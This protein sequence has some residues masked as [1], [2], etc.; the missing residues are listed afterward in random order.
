M[1]C[2]PAVNVQLTN[3]LSIFDN[4]VI[5]LNLQGNSTLYGQDLY[6]IVKNCTIGISP[7][8]GTNS[9]SAGN[10]QYS[11]NTTNI[12]SGT[13]TFATI[14]TPSQYLFSGDLFVDGN[15]DEIQ[16]RV[17]AHST[18]TANLQTWESSAGTVQAY[19]APG[20]IVKSSGRRQAVATKTANYTALTT[21][22][23][24]RFT[25]S[26]TLTLPAATGSGQTLRVIASNC[27]VVIDANG[28]ELIKGELTQTISG[29]SD[30]ILTDV[31]AGIWE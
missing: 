3:Q 11:G 30:F 24:I 31:A 1:T 26:A 13:A 15:A 7:T 19:V 23:V 27:T 14:G 28:A 17:Q 8:G 5:A 20:G 2:Q 18:Q 10:I 29:Y 21:D 16:V 25:S 22:E 12:A 6:H 9:A 4:F